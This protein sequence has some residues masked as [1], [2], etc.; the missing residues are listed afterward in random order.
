MKHHR[1]I[2]ILLLASLLFIG[3]SGVA[4]AI[5]EVGTIVAIRGKAFIE[6]DDK[7]FEAEVQDNLYMN[8]TVSTREASRV[9]MLF[10]DDS[11]LTLGENS[12][13]VIKEVIYSRHKMGRSVFN[14]VEG[15]MRSI[16]GRTQFEVHTP[17]AVAAARGTV[18]LFETGV[19][20]DGRHF[21]LVICTEGETLVSPKDPSQGEPVTL[22]AGTML[23]Y[24]EGE[25]FPT[26]PSP[27]PTQEIERLQNGTDSV[28]EVSIPGPAEVTVSPKP[29]LIEESADE[30]ADMLPPQSPP[31]VD[32]QPPT[33][34]T[35]PVDINVIFPQ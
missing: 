27:A 28:Y 3:L 11:V 34:A 21:T 14:L 9:K 17:T 23:M 31:I 18:I 16:A 6:R 33:P 32:Q 15:K 8:D 5:D 10:I 2:G 22:T 30:P 26:D 13:V 7:S 29:V 24:I 19:T 4:F 12:Q 35:E 20:E 25:P 1:L